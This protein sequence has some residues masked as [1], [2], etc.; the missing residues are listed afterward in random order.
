M[1]GHVPSVAVESQLGDFILFH[2]SLFHYVYNHAPGRR[3]IQCSWAGYPDTPDRLASCWR[4]A[5]W[6][7]S[8]RQHARFGDHPNP[9]VRAMCLAP[10]EAVEMREA[11]EAANLSTAFPDVDINGTTWA[12]EHRERTGVRSWMDNWLSAR[13]PSL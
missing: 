2:Q 7:F 8:P 9:S 11:A 3:V 1:W 13:N 5:W 4:N 10:A 6:P 12:I